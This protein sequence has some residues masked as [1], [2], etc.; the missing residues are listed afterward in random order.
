VNEKLVDR[1]YE[2]G[3]VPELWPAVLE[4]FGR[5]PGALGA[6]L[7]A[8]RGADIRWISSDI[9]F[10]EFVRDH[11]AFEGGQERTRRLLAAHH[12]GFVTDFD[13]FTVEEIEREPLFRDFMIPRG[14]GSGVATAIHSPSGD[15]FVVHAECPYAAGPIAGDIVAQLDAL[16]PHFARAALLSAR[17]ELKRVEAA[18]WALE[19]VGLPAAVLGRNGRAM[20]SNRLFDGLVP[21]LFQD[22]HAR[23]ALV[24]ARADLLLGQAIAELATG[25]DGTVRSIPVAAK[26]EQPPMIVHVLPIRGAAND[27]FSQASAVVV[28]TP[29][30]P[31]EVPT[32]DVI[33]GLFDLTPAE[34]RI[35]R[36][37]GNGDSAADIAAATSRAEQTVR[38]QLKSI[39]AK[40]GLH[41]Q[42]ELVGLLRGV[43][44]PKSG[45]S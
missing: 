40:T 14:G 10:D 35:A 33:Q 34:A 19:M 8:V 28:V 44:I 27:V 13:V 39:L 31:R 30:V 15:T 5:L 24:D 21:G 42:S 3:A 38:G 29:V 6:V 32:E 17:L 9:E 1:I 22:R 12:A 23:L 7:I 43:P 11:Y 37:I 2:A 4:D 20:A 25:G 41:R 36:A 45:P 26:E 16:R 18:A